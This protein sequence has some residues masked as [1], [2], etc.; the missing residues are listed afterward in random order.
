MAIKYKTGY[1]RK[2]GGWEAL[3][4][5][6]QADEGALALGLRDHMMK[7]LT[8]ISTTLDALLPDP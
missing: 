7:T 4:K 2:G 1:R 5:R 6:G 3:P 8:L